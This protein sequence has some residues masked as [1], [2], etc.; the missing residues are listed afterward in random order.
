MLST[1]SMVNARCGLHT[2]R[3]VYAKRRQFLGVLK[4]AV[5]LNQLLHALPSFPVDTSREAHSSVAGLHRQKHDVQRS[6]A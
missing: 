4:G 6:I 1:S 2:V 5:Q 3:W